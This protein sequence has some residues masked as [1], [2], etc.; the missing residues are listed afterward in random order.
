MSYIQ[1]I[2][3]QSDDFEG[4]ERAHETWLAATVGQRTVESVRV[5]R[6]R[7]RPDTYVLIVEFPSAEAAAINDN[8]PATGQIAA[9]LA[10]LATKP[11]TFMNLDLIRQD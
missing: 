7:D 1:V 3:I 5:C 6:D 9:A 4:I 2:E 8:L 10:A 11:L